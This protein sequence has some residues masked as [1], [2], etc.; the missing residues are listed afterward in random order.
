M[1]K[2][3]R[4]NIIRAEDFEELDYDK[5]KS[6]FKPYL[7]LFQDINFC[8]DFYS[9]MT[10][11][12]YLYFEKKT[13][14]IYNIVGFSFRGC[15]GFIADVR[16][17]GE[18]YLDFYCCSP[19]GILKDNIREIFENLNIIY[20]E[21]MFDAETEEQESKIIRETLRKHKVDNLL[22]YL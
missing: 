16:N 20:L 17:K 4:K 10:N 9:S 8:K 11:N 3:N 6:I 14:K 18:D 5:F 19:E 21:G 1:S 13:G 22:L 15:G 12:W 2:K 7:H